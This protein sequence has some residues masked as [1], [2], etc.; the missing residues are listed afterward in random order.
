MTLGLKLGARGMNLSFVEPVIIEG[1]RIYSDEI[2][3]EIP[4]WKKVVILYVVGDS[5]SMGAITRFIGTTWSFVSKPH[6]YYHNDGYFVMLF[7]SIDDKEEVLYSRP[8]QLTVNPL[9]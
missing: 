8:T 9:F 5:S 7:S 4:K 2:A 3:I 1:E 6:I